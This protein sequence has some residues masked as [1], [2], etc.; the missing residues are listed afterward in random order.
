[1]KTKH[2]QVRL[3]EPKLY[4][5]FYIYIYI[6]MKLIKYSFNKVYVNS[7]LCMRSKM[8]IRI[9]KGIEIKKI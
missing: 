3:M 8:I 1:M 5:F 2:S 9:S 7:R 4:V 6:Y